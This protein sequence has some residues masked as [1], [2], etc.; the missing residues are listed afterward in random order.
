MIEAVIIIGLVIVA[1]RAR[2]TLRAPQSIRFEIHH[3]HHFPGD[4]SYGRTAT[5]FSLD[6]P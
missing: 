3:Y 6:S 2:R 5:L 4:G 1:R